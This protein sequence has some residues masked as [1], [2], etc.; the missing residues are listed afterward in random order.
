MVA[1]DSTGF[2]GYRVQGGRLELGKTILS[3][4]A[5]VF[6]VGAEDVIASIAL[7]LVEDNEKVAVIDISGGLSWMLSGRIDAYDSSYVMHDS[8][9]LSENGQLHGRLLAS[10]YAT[11]Q[12]LPS[13]QEELL[14]AAIQQTALEDGEG[15]PMGLIPMIAIVEGFRDSDKAE[16]AGRIANLRFIESAGDLGAV[17]SLVR[18]SF[19]VDFTHGRSSDLSEGSAAA[20]LAKLLSKESA[21]SGIGFVV[22]NGAERLFGSSSVPRHGSYLRKSLLNGR[23]GKVYSSPS[24]FLLDHLLLGACPVRY[25]SSYLW[26]ALGKD[27]RVISNAF[28]MQNLHDDMVEVFIPKEIETVPTAAKEGVA[29][30]ETGSELERRILETVASSQNYTRLALTS[31]LSPEY[32]ANEVADH[33][34]RL[35]AEEYLGLVRSRDEAFA[36]AFVLLEPGKKRLFELG[37]NE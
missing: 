36:A 22:I 8:L 5:A 20:F 1:F 37:E 2:V 16:L 35:V 10:A 34:D 11:V 7:A 17:D 21:E 3:D 29:R 32:P 12:N 26:N 13:S 31:I 4:S 33:I 15:S 19:V 25:Y 27:P 28:V 23:F 18:S 14:N 6:G 9:V 30:P 24:S